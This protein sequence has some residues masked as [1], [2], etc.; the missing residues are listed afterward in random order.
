[1]SK[2]TNK[3]S[4]NKKNNLELKTKQKKD[5]R[6]D[7]Q[8]FYYESL[9]GFLLGSKARENLILK[10][11]N[12]LNKNDYFLE[13]GCAQGYYLKK[14][15]LKTNNVFGMDVNET[16]IKKAKKTKAKVK[17]ASAT[18]LPYKKDFFDYVLC[19]EVLEH[20]FNWKKS[21]KEIYRVTKKNGRVIVTVPLEHSLFWKFFSIIYP[22]E[23][24]RGHINLVTA[25]VVEEEFKKNG[26][27]LKQK[28][29]IH[30][31]FS[32]LNKILPQKEKISMYAFF[33]F[34]K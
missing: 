15:L 4:F 11:M 24:Y 31:P 13:I 3:K 1:M 5:N 27:K 25:S 17:V 18:N 16:F 33:I 28:K 12:F 22:P 7:N 10:E 30:S 29:F 9:S 23:E 20:V 8:N 32:T 2:F 19:T 21:V 34:E 26:F 14:A 6:T